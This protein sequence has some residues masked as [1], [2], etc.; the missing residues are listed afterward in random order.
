[1]QGITFEQV[2]NRAPVGIAIS[3]NNDEEASPIES[4]YKLNLMFEQ[5]IGRTTEELRQTGMKSITHPHDLKEE[6]NLIKKMQTGEICAYTIEK[7]FIK[8]DGSVI[9][10][11]SIMSTLTFPDEHKSNHIYIIR[12]SLSAKKWKKH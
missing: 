9:W 7:R 8:P 12:I 1:M 5:I 3:V 4:E 2:F 6:L 11:H 10:V